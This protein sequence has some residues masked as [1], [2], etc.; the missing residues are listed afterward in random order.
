[1]STCNRRI[2]V[3]VSALAAFL[4]ALPAGAQAPSPLPAGNI[5]IVVPFAAG[6]ATDVVT[7]LVAKSLSENIGRPVIVENLGGAGGVIGAQ[8]VQ[9]AAPDGLTLVMGTVSTHALNPLMAEKPP[10]DPVKDFTP[11]ALL[12]VVPNILVVNSNLPAKTLQELLAHLRSKPGTAYASSG[13][14]TPLHVSG[15]LLK[16]QAKLDITHVPYRGGGPAMQDVI[17]GQVPMMFDVLSGAA[18]FVRSGAVRPIGVT[19]KTR[20][21]AFPDIPTL[22]EAGLPDYETYT[23]N[24]IFGPADVPKPAVTYLNAELNKVIAAPEMQKRLSELS[25]D[26]VTAS[27]DDLARHVKAEMDKWR[28][29]IAAAGIR[30]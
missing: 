14:G 24:A 13:N 19:T 10:Y 28:P 6:G 1:M 5:T 30:Q 8:K 25:A 27:A 17:S 4:G 22:A 29:V 3:G 12:A 18:S 20:N 23:W 11:I 7:R 2:F 16:L 21:K 15:E 9:R 26:P